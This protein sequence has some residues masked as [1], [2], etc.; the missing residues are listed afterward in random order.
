[1]QNQK[2]IYEA[3]LADETLIN[4]QF[5][6][7]KLVDGELMQVDKPSKMIEHPNFAWPQVWQIYKEPKWYENIPDGG[8][9]CWCSDGIN[10]YLEKA[11][12]YISSSERLEVADGTY[13]DESKCAPL[14]KQE[15]QVFMDNA[16]LGDL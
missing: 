16:P 1:M 12:K 11:V 13:R 5:L 3:L 7:I 2:E 14:T 6:K 9:L 10:T 8:V 4:A 15:I